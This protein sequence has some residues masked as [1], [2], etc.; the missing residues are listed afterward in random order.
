MT[1]KERFHCITYSVFA[2]F[3]FIAFPLVRYTLHKR[4]A[5]KYIHMQHNVFGIPTNTPK[6]YPVT[7]LA[8]Y[9]ILGWMDLAKS[10]QFLVDI[11]PLRL[12]LGLVFKT[13]YDWVVK[14]VPV[15][16]FVNPLPTFRDF[17]TIHHIV[18]VFS[19]GVQPFTCKL[20]VFRL[21]KI[22]VIRRFGYFTAT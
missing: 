18:H 6:T 22:F 3:N 17:K 2:M 7:L 9:C 8:L 4:D 20:T 11:P 15:A 13:A 5:V 19:S 14:A 10:V 16:N 12:P 21:A 1:I